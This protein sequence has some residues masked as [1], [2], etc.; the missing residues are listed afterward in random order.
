[1]IQ[2]LYTTLNSVDI[3]R[4]TTSDDNVNFVQCAIE[5]K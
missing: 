2:C 1:M 3:K 5:I 4:G